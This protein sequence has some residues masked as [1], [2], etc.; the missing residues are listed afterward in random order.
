MPTASATASLRLQCHFLTTCWAHEGA[1]APRFP[2]KI[3][4][5]DTE[6]LVD[7]GSMVTLVR[8]EFAGPHMGRKICIQNVF[9][10]EERSCI[11]G[12]H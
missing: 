8:P 5:K 11:H 9:A 4:G 12:G 6:A 7:S 10:W 3:G 2:V 1:A